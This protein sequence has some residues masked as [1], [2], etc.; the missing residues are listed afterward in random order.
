[1]ATLKTL[2]S[3]I[4]WLK[5]APSDAMVSAIFSGSSSMTVKWAKGYAAAFWTA[6]RPIFTTTFA[7]SAD[8]IA[9]IK[10]AT[11]GH[12]LQQYQVTCPSHPQFQKVRTGKI[13]HDINAMDHVAHNMSYFLAE[14]HDVRGK[15][16]EWELKH[17]LGV[18]AYYGSL[19]LLDFVLEEAPELVEGKVEVVKAYI[20]INIRNNI[21]TAEAKIGDHMR[22][23]DQWKTVTL[24]QPAT[25]PQI[26]SV[27]LRNNVT[28]GT[29]HANLIYL[30]PT[31]RRIEYFEPNG[32]SPWTAGCV[33][34]LKASRLLP[35]G[36]TWTVPGQVY[37]LHQGVRQPTGP[38]ASLPRPLC[39]QFTQ[40]YALYRVL[41][42]GVP[43]KELNAWLSRGGP[44]AQY[45]RFKRIWEWV[46]VHIQRTNPPL[47]QQLFPHGL[48]STL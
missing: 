26:I 35:T 38:Q 37:E 36:F 1:M 2:Q 42:P 9:A 43:P 31:A 18:Q 22:G 32:V 40:L 6:N 45:V 44:D 34:T 17:W 24:P 19:V 8:L 30:D 33:R 15:N 4:Q 5:T 27:V 39:A 13:L 47:F 14:F 21:W 11:K 16:L 3:T 12:H 10:R 41:N 29:A 28:G 46:A 7:K 25:T 23:I 20:E 48:P